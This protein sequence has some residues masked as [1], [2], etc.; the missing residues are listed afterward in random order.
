MEAV[1]AILYP[2]DV[3][4]EGYLLTPAA[5]RGKRN[6][7]KIMARIITPH[8]GCLLHEREGMFVFLINRPGN[9]FL[10]IPDDYVRRP[11]NIYPLSTF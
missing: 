4:A 8:S 2:G 3:S 6:A 1:N 7:L 9:N 11:F 10:L 5:M